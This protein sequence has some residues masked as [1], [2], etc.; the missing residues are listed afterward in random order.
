MSF[1]FCQ[2]L[3]MHRSIMCWIILFSKR[4]IAK[5]FFLVFFVCMLISNVPKSYLTF[6]H[7]LFEDWIFF[8][9]KSEQISFCWTLHLSMSYSKLDIF[10][11]ESFFYPSCVTRAKAF[12]NW[13]REWLTV[14]V[15][16]FETLNAISMI[17]ICSECLMDHVLDRVHE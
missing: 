3:S 10:F 14:F 15:N 7:I 6:F 13:W 4:K 1:G 11:W 5:S 12:E 17:N 8:S 2:F 16:G 9:P